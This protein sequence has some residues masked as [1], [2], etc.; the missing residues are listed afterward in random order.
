[1]SE[2]SNR[3]KRRWKVA[4]SSLTAGSSL[5]YD[6]YDDLGKLLVPSGEVVSQGT[7]D[8]L[9]S[10]DVNWLLIDEDAISLSAS[11]EVSVAEQTRPFDPETLVSIET[12][13]NNT[14]RA[15]ESTVNA[16]LEGRS[17]NSQILEESI[18]RF[19]NDCQDDLAAFLSTLFTRE[20]DL[21]SQ[22]SSA[23]LTRSVKLS[24][25]SV[26]L[27]VAM[28][29]SPNDILSLGIAGMFHDLSL[30]EP[31]NQEAISRNDGD[32]TSIDCYLQHP[33]RSSK[34]VG[35]VRGLVP[36]SR[37]L[38]TQVHEE[39][40]GKG[41]PLGLNSSRIH[42]LARIL[43]VADIYLS[44]TEPMGSQMGIVPAD[45]MNCLLYHA[46]HGRLCTRAVRAF[47]ESAAIYPIGSRV[48]LENE[49]C[50]TVVRSCRT[51]LLKPSVLLDNDRDQILDLR[52]C[53]IRILAP[54]VPSNDRIGRLR[55]SMVAEP[56]WRTSAR[57][58]VVRTA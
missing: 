5:T 7:I 4:I 1:M 54:L 16:L 50:A 20:L 47:L 56:V 36:L 23:L 12:N 19:S 53:P 58:H 30:F 42:P 3:K 10:R 29:A 52:C 21:S 27:G 44:L 55:A 38:I 14:V 48:T 46:N 35:N 13:F 41:F 28:D 8:H 49:V 33:I 22:Y 31:E 51:N 45:A 17:A 2:T 34:L 40:D 26:A 9:L 25:L 32:V 39:L 57:D 15:L 37:L 24:A 11:E 18:H 6:L 43:N